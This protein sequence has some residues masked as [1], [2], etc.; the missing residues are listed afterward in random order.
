MTDLDITLEE[1]RKLWAGR[2]FKCLDTD[3]VFTMP[4]D[5]KPREFFPI[6]NGF[7]DVGDGFY[8]RGG[9]NIVEITGTEES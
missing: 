7:I 2:T 9:G 3:V 8:S 4:D 1:F 6:G 5:V